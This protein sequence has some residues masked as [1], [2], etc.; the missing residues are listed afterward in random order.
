MFEALV[1]MKITSKRLR[2]LRVKDPNK[3]KKITLETIWELQRCQKN[4]NSKHEKDLK[5]NKQEA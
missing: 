1:V 3:G 5:E 4:T 2:H